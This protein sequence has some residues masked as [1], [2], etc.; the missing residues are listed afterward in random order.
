MLTY[1]DQIGTSK[2]YKY[3]DSKSN[4]FS[5]N[6]NTTDSKGS[7]LPYAE[8]YREKSC[9]CLELGEEIND[10]EEMVELLKERNQR[11]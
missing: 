9:Q 4:N 2:G 6:L 5:N 7:E 3:K 1:E 8:T 11:L 10:L